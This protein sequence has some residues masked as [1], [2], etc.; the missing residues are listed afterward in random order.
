MFES[1]GSATLDVLV[2][3]IDWSVKNKATYDI[4][5]I[6]LS[7]GASLEGTCKGTHLQ[8]CFDIMSCQQLVHW[9]TH[10]AFVLAS[11]NANDAA[12]PSS[13]ALLPTNRQMT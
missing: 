8:A 13:A 9:S 10:T 12:V 4:T 1:D 2:S 5:A 6:N 7:L 3:A 11:F